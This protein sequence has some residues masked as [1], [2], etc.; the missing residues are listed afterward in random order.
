MVTRNG[1][2]RRIPLKVRL[3]DWTASMK[4]AALIISRHLLHWITYHLFDYTPAKGK[5]LSKNKKRKME[6]FKF[7]IV[8]YLYSV[9]ILLNVTDQAI[10]EKIQAQGMKD[11]L[12]K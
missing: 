4:F 9:K 7:C 8:S 2:E 11:K 10:S 1:I 5:T 3:L 12:L 6:S